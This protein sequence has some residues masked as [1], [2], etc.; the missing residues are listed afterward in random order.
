VT[1]QTIAGVDTDVLQ[2]SRNMAKF[3]QYAMAATRE[4]LDDASW[5][6]TKQEDLE[7]TVCQILSLIDPG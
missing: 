7:A 1:V 4:A 6:P 2:D 3:A 5:M